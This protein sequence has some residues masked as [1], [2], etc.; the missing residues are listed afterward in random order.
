MTIPRL[1]ENTMRGKLG[2]DKRHSIFW[3]D[4]Q[5]TAFILRLKQRELKLD[6]FVI[7]IIDGESRASMFFTP[8]EFSSLICEIL[9]YCLD[10][11]TVARDVPCPVTCVDVLHGCLQTMKMHKGRRKGEYFVKFDKRFLEYHGF[12]KKFIL[13]HKKGKIW[14]EPSTSEAKK[15]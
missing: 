4:R 14:I 8:G 7:S 6:S 11:P 10:M 1:K 2:L 12:P 13:F 9:K 5:H 3:T 15:A